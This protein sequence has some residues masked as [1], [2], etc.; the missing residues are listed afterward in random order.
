MTQAVR[1]EQNE[2]R[3]GY[4]D[5]YGCNIA[6][7]SVDFTL[8]VP[9]G[10]SFEKAIIERY[11]RCTRVLGSFPGGYSALM[12]VCA[13]LCHVVS[14]QKYMNMKH[15]EAAMEGRLYCWLSSF[16]SRDCKSICKKLLILFSNVK[17]DTPNHTLYVHLCERTALP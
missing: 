7:S 10:S 11:R 12:L 8:R 15:L 3:Q 2:Q 14:T 9:K 17:P 16:I 6:T 5:H 1:Y 13:R 4:R